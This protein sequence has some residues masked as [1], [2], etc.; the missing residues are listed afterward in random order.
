[1][2][3]RDP[4][5]A[6]E[7][8]VSF[9]FFLVKEVKKHPFFFL[10]LT[11][12]LFL[13]TM[14]LMGIS[15]V[16][17]QVQSKLN[18]HAKELL[19]SDLVVAARRDLF[20][21]EKK[22]LEAI[23][24]KSP[25][26][27]YKVVD[28]YSMIT[29]LKDSQVRLV[30]IR[31][32]QKGFPFYGEITLKT[33]K[34][35]SDG[36]FISKD[37]A[38]LWEVAVGDEFQIGSLKMKVDGVVQQ[39]SSQGLRGFSLAP[40]VYLPLKKIEESGLLKEGATGSFAYHYHFLN[41]ETNVNELKSAILKK[42]KD[43]AVR[44]TLP[45]ESSEQTG[46]VLGYLTD[47]M[48]LAAL[49]GLVLSLVGIFYLYQSHLASRLK[50]L[51]LLNLYGLSKFEILRGI[52]L[53]FSF[54]F[55]L[56]FIFEFLILTPIY[57]HFAPLLG[58]QIGLELSSTVNIKPLLIQ[59]PFLFFFAVAILVPLFMG[60]MRTPMGLQLKASKI[61]LGRFRFYDFTPFMFLLWGYACYLSHSY[62][63]GSIFFGALVL[64]FVLS[65]SLVKSLQFF[66]KKIIYNKG[67][68]NPTLESGIALRNFARSGH[69]LT[70]SFLSLAMGATLISLILQLDRMIQNEFTL[71]ESKPALF[72]FDIQED[73]MDPLLDFA[74]KQGIPLE[75]ITPMIRARM[76]KVNGE[77]FKRAEENSSTV[78]TRE[79]EVESRFR[80]RGLNLT[81]R[82]HLSK[83]ETLVEGE[84]F[85]EVTESLDR[86]AWIS[87][88]KRFAQRL[89]LKIGDKVSF[90][91]QGIEIDGIVRNFREVKWT[92]FYPNFFVNVEPGF[93]D[94]APKTYLSVFPATSK[95]AKR[96]FQRDAVTVFPNI[97]M[98]DV[99]EITNKLS[100]LFTK[101]RQ[102]IEI[103]S[104][105]S[106]GV[107]LV[108]LY[109]LS[110]DQ[111]YRR[112]YDLALMKSLGVSAGKLRNELLLEFGTLF[113]LSMGLGLFLG[114]AGA[115]VIG[116]EVFKLSISIDWMRIFVPFFSLSIL[117]LATILLSSW[118]ALRGKPRELLSDA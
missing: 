20:P 92:S 85:P 91:V 25:Y 64:V 115:L 66:L 30:E 116:R 34:F 52:L 58:E 19:T 1:M 29:F 17:D 61:S 70:L 3:S 47:F 26:E 83:G 97:S 89:N 79:D 16:S 12:T 21:E 44:V 90:D 37:L 112:Y 40:R 117:C 53:Q 14:G 13:G 65:T 75:G 67:L 56:V 86:P 99:E 96:K 72:L 49:I 68:L 5:R 114:W 43:N 106:L 80:N 35:H 73:Q 110:H 51:C 57:E 76:E 109:G 63:I 59:L 74:K 24:E 77:A 46:R 88:E 38:E 84:P 104:Y 39:D 10:L 105:L 55:L 101:S 28:I 50:D 36:F 11:F 7:P 93:I 82:R 8:C 100:T 113:F 71:D 108:I 32:I 111:V 81:Y 4:F 87:L 107:G 31:S 98:I 103:I 118:K 94:E 60:L 2:L 95:E 15:I 54:I 62:K 33:G 9:R 69:K 78:R 45:E 18:S 6:W 22:E 102:A 42:I 41:S 23:V 27:T 48:G